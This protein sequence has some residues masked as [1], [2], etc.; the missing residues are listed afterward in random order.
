MHTS[1]I[2]VQK[3]VEL[4]DSAKAL[5]TAANNLVKEHAGQLFPDSHD[6]RLAFLGRTGAPEEW[7]IDTIMA[8]YF[9]FAII[10]PQIPRDE[11]YLL[12]SLEELN[13]ARWFGNYHPEDEVVTDEATLRMQ[14]FHGSLVKLL[15]GLDRSLLS[16]EQSEILDAMITHSSAD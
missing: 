9:E 15:E 1:L 2:T 14:T 5:A 16:S 13:I 6:S 11:I 7:P 12:A 4:S 8:C 3:E 10:F